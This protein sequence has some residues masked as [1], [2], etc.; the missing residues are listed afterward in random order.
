MSTDIWSNNRH[1]SSNKHIINESDQ[2]RNT[3]STRSSQRIKDSSSFV[4]ANNGVQNLK[5]ENKVIQV[6]LYHELRQI[7]AST[8]YD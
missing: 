4:K 1:S 6:G 5:T 2:S 7:S 8:Y 3:L